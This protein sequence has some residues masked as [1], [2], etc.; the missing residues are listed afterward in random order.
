MVEMVF[1]AVLRELRPI[2]AVAVAVVFIL[3]HEDWAD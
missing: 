1:Q 2:T 3:V